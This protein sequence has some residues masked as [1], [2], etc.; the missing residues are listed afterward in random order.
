[1]PEATS[2]SGELIISEPV[3]N[4][5]RNGTAPITLRLLYDRVLTWE[6]SDTSSTAPHRRTAAGPGPADRHRWHSRDMTRCPRTSE[7]DDEVA[8]RYA[9]IDAVKAAETYPSDHGA[10]LT[11]RVLGVS[12]SG[13]YAYVA[14]RPAAEEQARQEH[15]L[16]AEIRHIHDALRRAYGAPRITAALRR[17][18]HHVNH[19]RGE[20]MMPEHG[21]RAITRR[22]RRGLTRPDRKAAPSPDLVGDSTSV[23][24]GAK[25]VPDITCPCRPAGDISPR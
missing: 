3:T 16:V 21:I 20:R 2:V 17:N 23:Q 10:T 13:H 5:I 6:V 8:V 11:C 7:R 12:R 9:F 24:P 14:A 25:L 15:K 4:A 19:K 18:G 1:M 22:R